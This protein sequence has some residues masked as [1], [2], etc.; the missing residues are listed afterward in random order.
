[1]SLLSATNVTCNYNTLATLTCSVEHCDALTKTLQ[2]FWE[3]ENVQSE[4]VQ[5]LSIDEQQCEDYFDKTATRDAN[6]RFV[7]RLPFREDPRQLGES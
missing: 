1:M 5:T 3:I 2:K 7:V 4:V 6:G